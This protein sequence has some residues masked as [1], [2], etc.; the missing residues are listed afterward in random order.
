MKTCGTCGLGTKDEN[1]LISCIK[2]KTLNDSQ[3]EMESCFYYIE[4]IIE[5]SEPL[6][7]LQH[8]LLKEEEL[9]QGKMTG[10]I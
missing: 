10:V 3:A 5:D 9:K 7:P 1:G 8:L 4:T 2:Y 6:P